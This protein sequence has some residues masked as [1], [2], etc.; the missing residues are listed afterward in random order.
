MRSHLDLLPYPTVKNFSVKNYTDCWLAYGTS[1][2][3]FSRVEKEYLLL[4]LNPSAEQVCVVI[5]DAY[6]G[7]LNCDV[8][9]A[10][11]FH[12]NI[13]YGCRILLRKALW[14][15]RFWYPQWFKILLK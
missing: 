8:L 6:S 15:R 14:A 7:K 1:L 9:A 5:S 13:S 11:C 12:P 10:W 2:Q 3:S 4:N